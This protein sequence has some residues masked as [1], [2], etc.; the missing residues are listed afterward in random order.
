MVSVSVLIAFFGGIFLH[1]LGFAL[2]V[3]ANFFDFFSHH[4]PILISFLPFH[5]QLPDSRPTCWLCLTSL[6]DWN[7]MD[8]EW[9]RLDANFQCQ[10][11]E[12]YEI[13][14]SLPFLQHSLCVS[15][16]YLPAL[17]SRDPVLWCWSWEVLLESS[18]IY[19]LSSKASSFEKRTLSRCKMSQ[20]R[21]K[22]WYIYLDPSS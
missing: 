8:S 2:P 7:H 20:S 21:K 15:L 5:C 3:F 13:S 10:V 22:E 12:E 16:C 9:R 6:I 19:Y 1:V 17:F 4:S 11:P 14:L 18:N